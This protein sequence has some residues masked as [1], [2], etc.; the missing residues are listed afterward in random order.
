MFRTS[1]PDLHLLP[2]KLPVELVLSVQ[3]PT[4]GNENVIGQTEA[5]R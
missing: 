3:Q 4:S 2:T 5:V 1:H